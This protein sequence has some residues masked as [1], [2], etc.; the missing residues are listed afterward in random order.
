MRRSATMK[1]LVAAIA[2]ALA[3]VGGFTAPAQAVQFSAGDAVLVLYGNNTEYY[4]NLGNANTVFSSGTSLNLSSVMSAVGGALPVEYTI[5]GINGSFTT[6]ATDI[7]AGSSISASNTSASGWTT[8]RRNQIVPSSY[9]NAVVNWQGQVSTIT[10]GFH[11][12]AA[13]DPASFTNAFGTDDR[14]ASAFPVRMSSNVDT[15]LHL[16]GRPFAGT[17]LP[18][19]NL[20]T[21]LLTAGGQF[22]VAPVPVPAAAVLF[23]TG[24]VGLIGVARRRLTGAAA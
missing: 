12:L 6:G 13:S 24:I 8:T 21:A 1:A 15:V 14:L 20:G 3:G 2:V 5:V 18:L 11:T 4:H 9:F 17:G 10:G 16:I 23:A 19:T 22:S 7:F